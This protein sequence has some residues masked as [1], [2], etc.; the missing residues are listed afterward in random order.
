MARYWPPKHLYKYFNICRIWPK[1]EDFRFGPSLYLRKYLCRRTDHLNIY[2]DI[3][4]HWPP[5]Y[6][7]KI[8]PIS[9]SVLNITFLLYLTHWGIQGSNITI[10][11]IMLQYVL[12][13]SNRVINLID[14][15]INL[16]NNSIIK[17]LFHKRCHR[18]HKMLLVAFYQI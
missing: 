12:A 10:L 13:L 7:W 16:W 9:L 14:I 2:K 1:I 15:S 17:Q 8:L 4:R 5:K 6:L 11:G 18:S 3:F